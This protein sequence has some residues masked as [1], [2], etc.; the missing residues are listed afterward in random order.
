MSVK[1]L[2]LSATAKFQNFGRKC[3]LLLFNFVKPK[4]TRSPPYLLARKGF[5]SA[6]SKTPAVQ[7]PKRDFF[8]LSTFYLI[9][10]NI[11]LG[12]F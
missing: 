9:I 5:E 6:S 3:N 1:V 7:R 10:I 4:S 11:K 12:I 8:G 2:N